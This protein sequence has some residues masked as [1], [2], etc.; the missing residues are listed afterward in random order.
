MVEVA[1]SRE[2]MKEEVEKAE[3]GRS[4]DVKKEEDDEQAH[5]STSRESIDKTVSKRVCESEKGLSSFHTVS[6][7]SS[8]EV[9]V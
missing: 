9:Q 1:K 2:D 5:E 3:K 8:G 7:L 6:H 4:K